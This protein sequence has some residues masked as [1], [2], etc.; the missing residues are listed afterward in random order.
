MEALGKLFTSSKCIAPQPWLCPPAYNDVDKYYG[1]FGEEPND[2]K[3]QENWIACRKQRAFEILPLALLI[4]L[5]ILLIAPKQLE[6]Y[7]D[8]VAYGIALIGIVGYLT[9]EY[10]AKYEYQLY[11]LEREMSGFNQK[12]FVNFKKRNFGPQWFEWI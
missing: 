5:I 3:R 9:A 12:E 2:D 7:I 6:P 8:D 10:R 4:A 11:T 1:R